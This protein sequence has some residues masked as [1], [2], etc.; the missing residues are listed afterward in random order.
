MKAIVINESQALV[1]TEAEIGDPGPHEISIEVRASAV[2]RADLMQRRGFYPPP[3]GA[4]EIM[5]LECA[6][7]V[8]SVG[9]A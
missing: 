4:S 6:G 7:V 9:S 5:G 3:Q 1:W 2:N 8:V